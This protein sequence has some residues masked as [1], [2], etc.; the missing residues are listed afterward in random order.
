MKKNL[1]KTAKKGQITAFVILGGVILF[2]FFLVLYLKP[3]F[4]QG[5]AGSKIEL[6]HQAEDVN[7]YIHDCVRGLAEDGLVEMGMHG[8]YISPED[9]FAAFYSEVGYA[10]NKGK[11]FPEIEVL[12]EELSAYIENNLKRKCDLNT[13]KD[14]LEISESNRVKTKSAFKNNVI[15]DVS[16]YVDVRKDNNTFKYKNYKVE[17][18][19]RMGKI[20]EIT[21]NIIQNPKKAESE[22]YIK[23][24]EDVTINRYGHERL[25]SVY[26]IRDYK[27]KIKNKDYYIF[28][29]AIKE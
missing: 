11:T 17:I 21:N 4:I 12:E 10:Y 19:V 26:M 28:A 14:N 15:V 18:P 20:W 13:F 2:L 3:S 23:S 16:W 9:Y 29:F 5:G 7:K 25:Q 22:D 6:A 8:G 27:S 24:L 1:Q